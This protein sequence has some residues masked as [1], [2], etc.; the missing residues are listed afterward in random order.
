MGSLFE[1]LET[2]EAAARERVEELEAELAALNEQLEEAREGL[3]RLR[4]ARETVAAVMAEMS[5][6]ATPA[7]EKAAA[8]DAVAEEE[9]SSP[10]AGAAGTT[11]LHS[12]TS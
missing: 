2:R 10:Y 1:E 6:D 7:P 8:A 3:E 5:A 12:N 4:I 11:P 9:A